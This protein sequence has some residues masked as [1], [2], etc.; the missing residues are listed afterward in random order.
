[1][2]GTYGLSSA[3]TVN[4]ADAQAAGSYIDIE[5]TRDGLNV[6][7]R[8]GDGKTAAL[9]ELLKRYGMRLTPRVSSPCG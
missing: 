6:F 3:N 1:M 5:L 7:E 4:A 9:V 8:Q 2:T